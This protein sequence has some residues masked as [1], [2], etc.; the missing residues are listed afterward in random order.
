MSAGVSDNEMCNL[1]Y[2]GQLAV[3]SYKIKEN[4]KCINEKD[5]VYMWYNRLLPVL[6][7]YVTDTEIIYTISFARSID[8]FRLT[9]DILV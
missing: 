5:Q 1:A 8:Q 7:I 6:A 3:L 9:V 4:T 2:T